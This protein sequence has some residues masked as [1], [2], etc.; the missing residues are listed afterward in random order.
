MT[1]YD[2]ALTDFN[3][4]KGPEDHVFKAHQAASGKAY[5]AVVAI[6]NAYAASVALRAIQAGSERTARPLAAHAAP[7]RPTRYVPGADYESAPEGSA[8]ADPALQHALS[9]LVTASFRLSKVTDL[10]SKE[11][12]AAD[13]AVS[14]VWDMVNA[15][16][17]AYT[18]RKLTEETDAPQETTVT[19]KG[20]SADERPPVGESEATVLQLIDFARRQGVD[21]VFRFADAPDQPGRIIV[22]GD[23]LLPYQPQEPPTASEQEE[24]APDTEREPAGCA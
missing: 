13:D 4:Y 14:A 11:W 16:V 17:E 18:A 10:R 23:Q 9:D 22:E 20:V 1:T 5:D 7:V 2:D 6:I 24:G 15:A 19:L 21:M 8:A 3:N 12:T